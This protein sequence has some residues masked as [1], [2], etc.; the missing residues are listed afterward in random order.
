[1]TFVWAFLGA[2]AGLT[3]AWATILTIEYCRMCRN[4]RRDE[5]VTQAAYYRGRA[6]GLA[7][8]R[9]LTEGEQT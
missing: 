9:Q 1:M 2:W 6:D 3:A 8:A 4:D 7:R 5:T